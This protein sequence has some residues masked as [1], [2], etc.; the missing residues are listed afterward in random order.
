MSREQGRS[1]GW[2]LVFTILN[3]FC[4]LPAFM[5]NVCGKS[6]D[7]KILLFGVIYSFR[8]LSS[9]LNVLCHTYTLGSAFPLAT[10]LSYLFSTGQSTLPP[11]P[12][13][14]LKV[15]DHGRTIVTL[16]GSWIAQMSA[17]KS[18]SSIMPT[19]NGECFQLV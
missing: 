9:R 19:W 11:S 8:L 6:Q 7:V 13:G 12:L 16:Q 1:R 10:H 14:I 17:L 2:I 4:H 5:F 3:E 15:M 18:C